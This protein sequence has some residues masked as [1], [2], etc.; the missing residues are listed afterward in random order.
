MIILFNMHFEHTAFLSG[1]VITKP[2]LCG[3]I[4]GYDLLFELKA[5]DFHKF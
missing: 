5:N 1:F 3:Q 4:P 2:L